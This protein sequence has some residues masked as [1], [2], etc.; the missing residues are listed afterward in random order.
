MFP[1]Q[2]STGNINNLSGA[3]YSYAYY[4]FRDL[5]GNNQWDNV[6]EPFALQSTAG[7]DPNDPL[8]VVNT[9]DPNLD[10]EMT[11]ELILGVEHSLMPEFVV[12]LNYTYRL[13]ED[14]HSSETTGQNRRDL[15]TGPGITD[16]LGRPWTAADFVD[17]GQLCGNDPF[18]GN[19]YCADTF[20]LAPQFSR[21]G[22]YL[23]E[24]TG[25][26]RTY[27]GISGTFNK[28]LSNG[29]SLRGFVNVGEAE[30]DIPNS[31]LSLYDPNPSELGDD[32]DGA[33]FMEESS[34]SGRGNIYLQSGWQWNLTGMYQV[35]PDRPWGF[36]LSANLYG[37]EGYP[38]PW[39]A[40]KSG[41]GVTRVTNLQ[42]RNTDATRTDDIF[43]T[44]LR[45][46]KTFAATSN[47]NLTFGLDWF[48]A[49]N[50]A[51]VL[52]RQPNVNVGSA[53]WVQDN[54]AP[55]VWK[56]SVRVSWR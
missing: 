39:Q 47:V 4:A 52:A 13:I 14:I 44:D 41:G 46:E 9:V 48:N 29:W 20:T 16:P 55:R 54:I 10:P 17:N 26:E 1:S 37:R 21:T 36:N 27:S 3:S 28:R 25:R 51:T 12:G 31:F 19:Q 53:G 23:L 30:W 38:V 6:S 5:N 45:A 15:I 11:T 22:G 33:V 42:G 35:M 2:L 49:L 43:T 18:S 32:Q 56:L 7:F 50:E 8:K 24:N 34:G 40:S